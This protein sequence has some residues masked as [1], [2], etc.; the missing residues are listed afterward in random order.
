MR[1]RAR[2]HLS[3]V[4]ATLSA[5]CFFP[6]SCLTFG[7]VGFVFLVSIFFFISDGAIRA[8]SPEGYVYTLV[9]ADQQYT[10]TSFVFSAP[11]GIL[12][13]RFAAQAGKPRLFVIDFHRLIQ[14]DLDPLSFPTPDA[15]TGTGRRHN[16]LQNPNQHSME[17]ELK[18]I[19][20]QTHVV[21]AEV[22]D[23]SAPTQAKRTG[24]R[25]ADS[26][27]F[28]SCAWF[29]FSLT[30][31]CCSVSWCSARRH[32]SPRAAPRIAASRPRSC[33]WPR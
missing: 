10:E 4:I 27:A 31:T 11:F 19:E 24:P 9:C 21:E 29:F 20:A 25:C 6:S 2:V 26:C 18:I 16:L 13:D 28:H 1:V 12:F 7:F 33:P 30:H 8:I 17:E 3:L 23:L 15:P 14:I 5:S 32:T 22:V